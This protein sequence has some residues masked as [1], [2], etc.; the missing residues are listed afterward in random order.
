MVL[1]QHRQHID[2]GLTVLVQVGQ[3]GQVFFADR[4]TGRHTDDSGDGLRCTTRFTTPASATFSLGQARS[5][6][7]T[8]SAAKNH[9][10]GHKDDGRDSR[11][12]LDRVVI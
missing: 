2:H 4:I 3:T 6:L 9:W 12:L 7:V 5:Q 11:G 10:G 1:G 8:E